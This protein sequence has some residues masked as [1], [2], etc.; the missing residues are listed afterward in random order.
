ML[1]SITLAYAAV[2]AIVTNN[3]EDLEADKITNPNRP[4]VTGKMNRSFALRAGILCLGWSLLISFL[5]R[6]E[7]FYCILIISTV[8][9]LYSCRPFRLK[10]I[11]FLSKFLIAFNSFAVAVCGFILAGGKLAEFPIV[12]AIFILVPLALAANFVDIKDIPGDKETG[13][14]TLPVIL[15]EKTALILIA[16]FTFYTYLMAAII[17]N[18]AWLYPV[19]AVAALL[20]CYLLFRK[21]F[22]ERPVF[23]VYILSL[24]ALSG[25]LFLYPS[26]S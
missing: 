7:M 8:Y 4:L 25:I 10:R 17:L 21:P 19:N 18:I 26:L 2:F 15:G 13:V 16:I 6:M 12:W 24:F 3:I 11:P 22:D 14:K 23:L 20:H 9:Y 5:I 1:F